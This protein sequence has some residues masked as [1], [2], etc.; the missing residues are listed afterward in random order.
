MNVVYFSWFTVLLLMVVILIY[1]LHFTSLLDDFTRT[2]GNPRT[3]AA[4]FNRWMLPELIVHTLLTVS[5]IVLV[6]RSVLLFIGHLLLVGRDWY[7][8]WHKRFYFTAIHLVRDAPR[9]ETWSSVYSGAYIITVFVLLGKT[10]TAALE[11]W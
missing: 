10:L 2:G 7:L 11:Y 8:L 9:R 5:F 1:R 4:R 6:N 3:T